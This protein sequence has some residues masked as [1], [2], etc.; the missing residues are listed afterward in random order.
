MVICFSLFQI[1][2]DRSGIGKYPNS[3]KF[4]I[5]LLVEDNGEFGAKELRFYIMKFL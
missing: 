4:R 5:L 2:E 3:T 1:F